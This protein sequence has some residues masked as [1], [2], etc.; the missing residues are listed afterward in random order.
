MLSRDEVQAVVFKLA[1][2][3]FELEAD[4]LT[5]DKD[6]VEDFAASSVM[7]LEYLVM[8]ERKFG[9]KFDIARVEDTGRFRELIDLVMEQL[10][11][12]AS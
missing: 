10:A 1:S 4:E 12:R 9:F 3:L 6:I 5:E 8:L 2:E 7:R 11:R